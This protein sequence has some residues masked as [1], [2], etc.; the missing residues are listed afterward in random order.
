MIGGL[1]RLR[2]VDKGQVLALSHRVVSVIAAQGNC[3]D[4][5]SLFTTAPRQQIHTTHRARRAAAA[6]AMQAQASWSQRG[7]GG[8]ATLRGASSSLQF[9]LGMPSSSLGG[10]LLGKLT[11]SQFD[12]FSGSSQEQQ[13]GQG[14]GGFWRRLLAGTL[15]SRTAKESAGCV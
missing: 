14:E 10:D 7:L 13:R 11:A 15:V 9:S 2:W 4:Q 5:P 12:A 6:A 8:G 1:V 3:T